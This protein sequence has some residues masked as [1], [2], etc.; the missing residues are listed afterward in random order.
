ML[1]YLIILLDETSTSYCVWENP[2]RERKLIHPETLQAGI[3]FA[4]KENLRVQFV[5]PDY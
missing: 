3:V 4:M 2:R 1:A 5:Y